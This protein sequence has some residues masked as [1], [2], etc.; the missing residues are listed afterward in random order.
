[1]ISK[2]HS[3][4]ILDFKPQPDLH[5]AKRLSMKKVP[6]SHV[7]QLNR[8]F[9]LRRAIEFDL[10]EDEYALNFTPFTQDQIKE[11]KICVRINNRFLFHL[12]LEIEFIRL[13]Q[14]L[15]QQK[16]QSRRHWLDCR[17][18]RPIAGNKAKKFR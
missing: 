11:K 5:T 12:N 14:I 3:T 15:R 2:K 16:N 17:T 6:R 13:Y 7:Q 8:I 1:M 9:K 4:R 18:A 10:E